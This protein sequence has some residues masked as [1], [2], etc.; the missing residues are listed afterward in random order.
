MNKDTWVD[1]PSGHRWGF[2]KLCPADQVPHMR[3]WILAEGYPQTEID[4][5]GEH[6]YVRCWLDK[7]EDI[8]NDV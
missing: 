7:K 4:S 6:W 8:K 5:Y 3:A 1:P 2:P